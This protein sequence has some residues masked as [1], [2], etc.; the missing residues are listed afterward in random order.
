MVTRSG[1]SNPLV[2]EIIN[3]TFRNLERYPEITKE[4]IGK[5]H[6]LADKGKLSAA[7]EIENVLATE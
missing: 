5:L 7:K 3:R 6:E 1:N 2:S 4:I